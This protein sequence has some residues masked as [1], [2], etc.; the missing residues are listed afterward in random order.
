MCVAVLLSQPRQFD[1]VVIFRKRVFF[2]VRGSDRSLNV[3]H[4]GT[5]F[6]GG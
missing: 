5:F 6:G 4:L 2:L 1:G 3:G